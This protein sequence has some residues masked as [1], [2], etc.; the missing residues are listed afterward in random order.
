MIKAI[1][2]GR[3][4]TI[5]ALL[6]HFRSIPG[7]LEQGWDTISR[8]INVIILRLASQ[9]PRCGVCASFGHNIYLS[10]PGENGSNKRARVRLENSGCGS[11]DQC[12]SICLL[13]IRIPF[14]GS[15][16]S[17]VATAAATRAAP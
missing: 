3:C 2:A 7:N 17:S 16:F 5:S 1:F 8:A 9:S 4:P 12:A 11:K 6:L 10:R 13:S 14:A 15:I